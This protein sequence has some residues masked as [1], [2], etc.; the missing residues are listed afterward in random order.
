MQS[1]PP[2]GPGRID[3]FNPV[4]FRI[5][6]QPIDDTI[7]NSDMVPIWNMKPRQGMALHWDGLSTSLR[8]VTLSSALG[9]G[10]SRKSID[11]ESLRGVE[12]WMLATPAPKYPFPANADL[13]SAGR[14]VYA[15][16]CAPCHAFGQPRTGTVIPLNEIGTDRHRLSSAPCDAAASRSTCGHGTC[17][18]D[19]AVHGLQRLPRRA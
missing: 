14:Q 1:R 3:P 17:A 5:L 11:L 10:A 16:T 15:S 7:G 8:E 18:K 4:K 12:A 9:D 13:A 19:H 6:D 2:W